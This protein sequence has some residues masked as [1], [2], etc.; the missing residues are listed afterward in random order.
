MDSV[1]SANRVTNEREIAER[2][3]ELS[4]KPIALIIALTTRCNSDCI[5]CN[6]KEMR[7]DLPDE[8]VE[9]ILGI[10][11]YLE[12]IMWQGGEVFLDKR[13]KRMMAE[14]IRY[15]RLTHSITTN[16]QLLNEEWV[17]LL[18][19]K[20]VDLNISIDATTAAVYEKIRKGCRFE[21]LLNNLKLLKEK[22]V[23]NKRQNMIVTVMKANYDKLDDFVD[24]AKEYGFVSII[25][26]QARSAKQNEE[27][28]FQEDDD[29]INGYLGAT[30]ARLKKQAAAS[31]LIFID[32]LT[33]KK[34][35]N[36]KPEP[37]MRETVLPC[38][39]DNGGRGELFCNTPWKQLF[40]GW[41]GFV[42]PSCLCMCDERKENESLSV[43]NIVSER[44]ERIWN[45][46]K[47]QEMRRRIA[48]NTYHSACNPNCVNGTIPRVL[49]DI[50][51]SPY[52]P[53]GVDADQFRTEYREGHRVI[54]EVLAKNGINPGN[55][56][57]VTPEQLAGAF[58][59][60]SRIQNMIQLLAQSD[61][62]SAAEGEEADSGTVRENKERLAGIYPRTLEKSKDD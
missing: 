34:R 27:F 24:F 12:K 58:N 35:S 7:W 52:R 61:G 42:Y 55:L 45:G 4:S 20:K 60:L 36:A 37:G 9:D 40:I 57:S 59:E 54:D 23:N 33:S 46:P 32:C 47:M 22:S 17:D 53:G 38:A 1:S 14:S 29:E 6:V 13:F 31:E 48:T 15:P 8:A 26:Q 62:L 44:L 3:L 43:G 21:N 39:A 56:G 41:E 11:P 16:G 19:R 28:I 10:Y 18:N 5:M 25:F 49:R 51:A 30:M 50:G 2:K